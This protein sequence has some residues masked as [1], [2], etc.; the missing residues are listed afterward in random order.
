[1]ARPKMENEIEDVAVINEETGNQIREEQ[2]AF[3]SECALVIQ[4][5]GDGLPFDEMQYQQKV[6]YHMRRSAEELYDAC[7]A[8]LVTRVHLDNGRWGEFLKRVGLEDRLARRMIQTA[9]KFKSPETKP[10]LQAAANKSKVF[11]LLVLDDEEL[12]KVAQG[13]PDAP[14]T[15][16]EIDRMPTSELRKAL[17]E[18]RA[19]H[20][21]DRKVLEAKNKTLD[22][23][24]AEVEKLK[25]AGVPEKIKVNHDERHLIAELNGDLLESKIISKRIVDGLSRLI[26]IDRE[27]R[28]T[29]AKTIRELHANLVSLAAEFGQDLDAENPEIPVWAQDDNE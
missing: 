9:R 18:S 6:G 28:H 1:M 12:V 11:E 3:S 15:L 29:M 25:S 26:D 24:Q 22:K 17:R 19:D 8:L 20:G 5:Y 10:L 4:E 7:R 16:D 13:S 21:A 27:H 2:A 14:V 23:L